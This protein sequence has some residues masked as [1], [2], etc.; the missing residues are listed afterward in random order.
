MESLTENQLNDIASAA[1]FQVHDRCFTPPL[2]EFEHI[3]MQN[4]TMAYIKTAYGPLV[5]NHCVSTCPKAQR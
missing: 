2:S 1:I 4:G 5:G 3:K